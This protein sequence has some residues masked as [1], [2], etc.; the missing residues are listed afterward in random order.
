MYIVRV[1][2]FHQLQIRYISFSRNSIEYRPFVYSAIRFDDS[3]RRVLERR[4]IENGPAVI[5]TQEPG[6]HSEVPLVSLSVR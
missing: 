6:N 1:W 3:P 4:P 2:V 5:G